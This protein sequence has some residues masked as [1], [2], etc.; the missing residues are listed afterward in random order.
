VR[1]LVRTNK[2]SYAQDTTGMARDQSALLNRLGE[3]TLTDVT[4]RG[5][6]LAETLCQELMRSHEIIYCVV[7]AIRT[8]VGRQVGVR[9]TFDRR[10]QRR[11][12]G[13]F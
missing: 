1:W 7:N 6:A 12:P 3:L 9:R 10:S 13:C 4:D 8:A 2:N 5:M 11:R